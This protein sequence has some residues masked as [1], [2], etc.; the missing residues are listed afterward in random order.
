MG[1]HRDDVTGNT[2]SDGMLSRAP[3]HLTVLVLWRQW[4]FVHAIS[5]GAGAAHDHPHLDPPS[6]LSPPPKRVIA[7]TG[8]EL[9]ETQTSQLGTQRRQTPVVFRETTCQIE[10]LPELWFKSRRLRWQLRAPSATDQFSPYTKLTMT[11]LPGAA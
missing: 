7:Q 11:Q 1:S 10:P 5:H 2:A 6:F 8:R 9:P 4:G 3:C